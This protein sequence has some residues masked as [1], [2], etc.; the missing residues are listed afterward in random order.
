MSW[1]SKA[2]KSVKLSSS[3][4]EFVDLSKTAKEV[5]MISQLI[6]S[7]DVKLK[8]SIIFQD[9]IVSTN[10]MASNIKASQRSKQ[11]T[12]KMAFVAEFVK[13]NLLEIK[14][15]RTESKTSNGI[16]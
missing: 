14:F 16:T 3:E 2:Q 11:L 10:F 1:K 9:D 5:R 4:A 12:V 8:Q 6:E 15:V 7:I 13:E